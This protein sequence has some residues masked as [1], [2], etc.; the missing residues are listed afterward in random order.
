MNNTFKVDLIVALAMCQDEQ[1][2][3]EV[4]YMLGVDKEPKPTKE[5]KQ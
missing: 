4:A 5:D 1:V 2:L 3:K